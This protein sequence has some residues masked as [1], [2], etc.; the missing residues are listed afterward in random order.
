[1]PPLK[2][3]VR[4][5][6]LKKYQD[7]SFPASY[8]SVK[9]FKE[10]LKSQLNIDVSY[11]TLRSILKSNLLYQTHVTLPKK[12]KTR[13]VYSQGVGI[14]ALTDCAYLTLNQNGFTKTFIFLLVMDKMS[15]FVYSTPVSRVNPTELK[16]AY[17]LLFHKK[18]C[19]LFPIIRYD[20]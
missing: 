3:S 2:D 17:Q 16:K 9:K 14:E 6:I 15:R 12:F 20:R 18:H 8:Q 5:I 7:P 13:K 1:M 4:K 19:P 10:A 11:R